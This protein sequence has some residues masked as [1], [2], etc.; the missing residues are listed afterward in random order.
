MKVIELT[1][2]LGLKIISGTGNLEREVSGGYV[3]DLLSDVIGNSAENMAWVTIQ[4]H[5][6]I[7]AVASLKDLSAIII[8]R[9]LHPDEETVRL[10]E[11]EQV[12]LLGTDR[13]SFEIAGLLY[14]LLNRPEC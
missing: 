12:P 7:V 9:G 13:S 10:S 8:A 14:N 6:N 11:K 4:T 1:E 2:L 5:P 3:S